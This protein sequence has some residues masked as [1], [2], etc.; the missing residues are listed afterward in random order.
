METQPEADACAVRGPRPATLRLVRFAGVGGL[1]ALFNLVI[2]HVGTGVLGYHYLLSVLAGFLL[3]NALGFRL[4]KS[5][6]F[7][8]DQPRIVQ[9]MGRYYLVMAASLGANLALTWLLVGGAGIHYL[10][11][12]VI[13]SSIFLVLNFVLHA[14]LTFSRV[15]DADIS[16]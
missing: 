14:R 5:F 3:S 10:L 8:D 4:N 16:Q 6:T 7:E 11:A 9:Q 1:C 13:V 15:P 12:S 2:L